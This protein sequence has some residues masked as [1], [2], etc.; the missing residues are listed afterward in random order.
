[1]QFVD[2]RRAGALHIMDGSV[3]AMGNGRSARDALNLT[4][5]VSQFASRVENL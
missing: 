1:M 3:L 2:S 5:T 4:C